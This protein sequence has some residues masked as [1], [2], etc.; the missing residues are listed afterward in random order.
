MGWFKKDAWTK[1]MEEVNRELQVLIT[2]KD[3]QID[4][5]QESLER[6]SKTLTLV[7]EDF[8]KAT[9]RWKKAVK[10]NEQ[11]K[12][13]YCEEDW[14]PTRSCNADDPNLEGQ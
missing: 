14:R 7:R 11:L 1:R 13:F 6:Q 5:L 2:Q 10:E 12:S 4:F 3:K 8:K 9:E